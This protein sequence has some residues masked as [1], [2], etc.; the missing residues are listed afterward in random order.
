[1]AA[2]PRSSRTGKDGETPWRDF[3]RL[4]DRMYDLMEAAAPPHEAG[5]PHDAA[6][7]ARTPTARTAVK[8]A[9]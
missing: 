6:D 8:G 3:G 9:G 5:G 1:M 7:T 2:L 4:L